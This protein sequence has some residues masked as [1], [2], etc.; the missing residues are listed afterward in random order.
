MN[1]IANVALAI[2]CALPILGSAAGPSYPV[3]P[4]RL[5]V[6]FPPGSSSNDILGRALAQRLT[7]ALGEQVVV[8]NRSGAGGTVG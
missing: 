6:P 1:K 8:D 7:R 2:A 3:R 5:I 4:I